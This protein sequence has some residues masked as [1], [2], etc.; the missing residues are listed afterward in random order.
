MM[1]RYFKILDTQDEI[2]IF[3]MII[4]PTLYIKKL[5]LKYLNII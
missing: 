3:S 1:L 5:D 4:Y 2:I